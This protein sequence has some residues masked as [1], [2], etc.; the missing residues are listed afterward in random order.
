MNIVTTHNDHILTYQS[1]IS[2]NQSTSK[3]MGMKE[4]H[5]LASPLHLLPL[6]QMEKHTASHPFFPLDRQRT[7]FTKTEEVDLTNN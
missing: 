4:P 7:V 1:Q 2:I 3:K 6:S 5:T